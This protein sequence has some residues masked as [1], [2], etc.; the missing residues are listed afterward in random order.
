MFL[1]AENAEV[2]RLAWFRQ[3]INHRVSQSE[4]QSCTEFLAQAY[5]LPIRSMY[6]VPAPAILQSPPHF[7][8]G[9]LGRGE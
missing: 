6:A 7:S 8:G 2:L 5:F 4:A 3:I 9:G 1:T